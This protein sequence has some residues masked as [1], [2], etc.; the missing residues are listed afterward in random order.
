[1][2]VSYSVLRIGDVYPGSLILIFIDPGSQI[3]DP[4][5]ATKEM[6]EKIVVIPFFV[7]TNFTILKMILFLKWRRKK[8][9]PIIE[10]L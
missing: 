6:G 5:T 8:F 9:G 10:E 1:M 3:P 7:A 2:A 4:E